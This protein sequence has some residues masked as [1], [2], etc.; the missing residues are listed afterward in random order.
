MVAMTTIGQ[1]YRWHRPL[2]G[3]AGVMAVLAVVATVGVFVDDRILV[4]VPIWTKPLK[5]AISFTLYGF[6]L[7]WLLAKLRRG[8]RAGWWAGTVITVASVIEMT[9]IVGQVIRGRQSHFNVATPLDAT[10][11]SIMGTTILVLWVTN[12]L[13]AILLLMDRVADP[14]LAWAVRFGMGIMLIGIS[15]GF[16]MTGPTAEQQ[17][18]I[19]AGVAPAV[20]GAHSVGVPDG[21]PSIPLTGWSTV[22]GDLRIPH[23]VGIHALQLLPLLVLLLRRYP[24]PVQVRLVFVA[25]GTYAGLVGLV[26]WQALR[27]QSLT[28]PDGLT[29]GALGVLLAVAG[30]TVA[31]LARQRAV[32]AVA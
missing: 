15:L 5:F 10:L 18:Q 25:A 9:I 12:L 21:G 29:L 6:T 26:L 14:A 2:V 32:P 11:F 28:H 27:G 1:V 13:V 16:L 23:F 3:F 19:A 8:R 17:R 20:V 4:G 30:T 7:A 31:L 24:M 22:G